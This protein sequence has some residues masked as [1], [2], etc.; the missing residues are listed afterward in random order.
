MAI[1]TKWK[2][3]DVKH[4]PTDGGVFE[5]H[6]SLVAKSGTGINVS[7][8]GEYKIETY[9]A[10]SPNFIPFADL[11]EDILLNWIWEDLGEKKAEI[12]EQITTQVQA[13]ITKRTNEVNGLPW[14]I[15]DNI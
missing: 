3:L 6:W 7:R 1:T 13:N 9:D 12:E 5:I 2:I 15:Q 14:T 11:T 4:N 8:D 10:S